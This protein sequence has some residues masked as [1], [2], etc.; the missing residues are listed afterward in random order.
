LV[1]EHDGLA[2]CEEFGACACFGEGCRGG[3]VEGVDGLKDQAMTM[4][5]GV[6]GRGLV[7][8]EF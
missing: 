5:V 7:G 2:E 4:S 6:V 3:G 1:Q 8:F